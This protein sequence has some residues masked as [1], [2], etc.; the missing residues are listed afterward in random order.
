MEAHMQADS[1][2]AIVVEDS[3][4][5]QFIAETLLAKPLTAAHAAMVHT[6]VRERVALPSHNMTSEP[7]HQRIARQPLRHSAAHTMHFLR[8][9]AAYSPVIG[10]VEWDADQ[11]R[12]LLYE[13]TSLLR[14]D[15]WRSWIQARG[16]IEQ[17]WAKLR[18][19]PLSVNAH[20]VLEHLL[21]NIQRRQPT[22]A[23]VLAR[24]REHRFVLNSS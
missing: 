11:V 8:S 19:A 5:H 17:V 1:P 10:A 24:R 9:E 6:L 13:P 7:A 2:R 18:R 23:E 21:E 4:R 15:P 12:S 3:S 20:E 14:T 22:S 16:G